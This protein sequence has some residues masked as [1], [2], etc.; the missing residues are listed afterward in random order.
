MRMKT[1]LSLFVVVILSAQS[2]AGWIQVLSKVEWADG[3]S[4]QAGE[5]ERTAGETETHWL[6]DDATKAH[7]VA[8]AN[9][10]PLTDAEAAS[11]LLAERAKLLEDIAQLVDLLKEQEA[12][13]AKSAA[14]PTVESPTQRY[15]RRKAERD[16]KNRQALQDAA[17]AA[18]I[19]QANELEK[20]NR[21]L[22]RQR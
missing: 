22:R 17:A 15:Y 16:A 9:A 8:K 14:A 5:V 4:S 19:R 11:L 1:F 18:Q 3:W 12:V 20:L 2:Q 10:R 7:H 13:T 6:I 21:E